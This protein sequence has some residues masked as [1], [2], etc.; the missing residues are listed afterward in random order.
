[1]IN[2]FSLNPDLK[3]LLYTSK[4]N[5][6]I[7]DIK[8]INQQLNDISSRGENGKIVFLSSTNSPDAYSLSGRYTVNGNIIKATVNIKRNKV[9]V[10]KF[11]QEGTTDNLSSLAQSIAI[12]ASEIA[13]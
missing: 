12:K 9:I 2:T 13:K 1:M 3:N 7:E 11:E 5:I 8:L 10:S 4:T 6:N